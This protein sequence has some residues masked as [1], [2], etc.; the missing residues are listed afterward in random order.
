[1]KIAPSFSRLLT[2]ALVLW[3]LSGCKYLINLGFASPQV[4]E[5]ARISED[6]AKSTTIAVRG[7]VEKTVPLLNR[8]AYQIKDNS[9]SIWV[10]SDHRKPTIG[11]EIVVEVVP[12]YQKITITGENLG[13]L[14]LREV[15]PE[16]KSNQSTSSVDEPNYLPVDL[17]NKPNKKTR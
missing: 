9:G 8:I 15:Q 5:I 3:S 2:L 7:R 10:V 17:K 14:Y 12:K 1:M 11:E 16:D 6:K 13:G 4:V